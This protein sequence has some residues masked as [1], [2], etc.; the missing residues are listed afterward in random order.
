MSWADL[1]STICLHY[2]HRDNFS[3]TYLL[4]GLSSDFTDK[5]RNNRATYSMK[6]CRVRSEGACIRY[7]DARCRW[8]I[9]LTLRPFS[10]RRKKKALLAVWVW[11]L[12]NLRVGLDAVMKN[13]CPCKNSNSFSADEQRCSS[14]MWFC[15]NV[16]CNCVALV[17]AVIN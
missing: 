11:H 6:I 13:F 10:L 8:V 9:S 1:H 2:L 15:G 17:R 4:R 12:V 16:H 14:K 3:F 7:F 5:Y